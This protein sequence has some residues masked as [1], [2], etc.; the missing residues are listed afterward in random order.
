M[1]PRQ[2][3]EQGPGISVSEILILAASSMQPASICP[4]TGNPGCAP[5]VPLMVLS[6]HSLVTASLPRGRGA[7]SSLST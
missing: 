1:P 3:K 7:S 2:G 6:C 5:T 4:G